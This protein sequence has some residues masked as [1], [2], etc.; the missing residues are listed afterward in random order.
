MNIAI[1]FY[2]NFCIKM[3][4]FMKIRSFSIRRHYGG[5]AAGGGVRS[6]GSTASSESEPP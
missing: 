3:L 2:A 6:P 4:S 1:E 5:L